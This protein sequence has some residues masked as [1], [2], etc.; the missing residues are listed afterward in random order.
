MQEHLDNTSNGI[1]SDVTIPLD[2]QLIQKGSQPIKVDIAKLQAWYQRN[3]HAEEKFAKEEHKVAMEKQQL[4]DA[5]KQIAYWKNLGRKEEIELQEMLKA[6]EYSAEH[7]MDRSTTAARLMTCLKTRDVSQM[8][9]ESLQKENA[10]LHGQ[11]VEAIHKKDMVNQTLS[12]KISQIAANATKVSQLAANASKAEKDLERMQKQLEAMTKKH[13]KVTK[14]H[15]KV[16]E[17]NEDLKKASEVS[18]AQT[19]NAT[20][21]A[22]ELHTLQV[23]HEEIMKAHENLQKIHE[24]L[25]RRHQDVESDSRAQIANATELSTKLQIL[26]GKH[27][28]CMKDITSINSKAQEI[29]NTS[30]D[31]RRAAF[32]KGMHEADQKWAEVVKNATSRR[33][34]AQYADRRALKKAAE[35]RAMLDKEMKGKEEAELKLRQCHTLREIYEK[36]E[37]ELGHLTS[38]T[39]EHLISHTGQ[40][41]VFLQKVSSDQ[42]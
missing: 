24:V 33:D 26:Q 7:M 22:M 28:N 14:A 32:K 5:E 1:D 19:A 35:L 30:A 38:H 17:A 2:A 23:K 9:V 40:K 11:V 34:A 15:E 25:K 6:E 31:M 37:M 36:T 8:E 16:M 10:Y 18:R 12:T 29:Y 3:F 4:S 21:L 13:E 20:E 27:E 39:D 41:S 42:A